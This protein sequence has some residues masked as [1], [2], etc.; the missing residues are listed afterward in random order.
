[1]LAAT[2]QQMA[3]FDLGLGKAQFTDKFCDTI[4]AHDHNGHDI[5]G[6]LKRFGRNEGLY[7]V[8]GLKVMGHVD[9]M[10]AVQVPP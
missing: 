2:R 3:K 9:P 4:L 6:C 7:D 5:T 1:V 10:D 8:E